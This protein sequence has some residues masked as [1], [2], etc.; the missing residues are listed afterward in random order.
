MAEIINPDHSSVTVFKEVRDRWLLVAT[1]RL[2]GKKA[3]LLRKRS[4]NWFD[5]TSRLD[6]FVVSTADD[7]AHL[8]LLKRYASPMIEDHHKYN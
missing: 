3:V 6:E 8:K 1:Y 5:E 2:S 7:E 4:Y